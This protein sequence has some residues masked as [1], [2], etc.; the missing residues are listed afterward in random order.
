M[1]LKDLLFKSRSYRRFDQSYIISEELLHSLIELSIYTPSTANKQPLKYHVSCD[2][3]EN[4]NIFKTLS[5]AGYL[6]DWEGPVSGEQPSAYIVIIGD[7]SIS[8]NFGIDSGIAGQTIMLGAAEKG[9]GGCMIASI[10]KKELNEILQLSD[11]Q[12]ILLV[13]ALGKPVE[14]IVLEEITSDNNIKYWR[15]DQGVHHVPK[16]RL[17][18]ILI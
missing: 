5:W 14:K 18:D 1:V 15:D 8:K 11:D 7:K 6:K 3:E 10:K 12:E 4:E 16:R 13:L 17:Q 2:R 9:I